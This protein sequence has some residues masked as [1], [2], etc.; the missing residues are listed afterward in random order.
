MPAYA[1]G[2]DYSN[3]T[4]S[5][6]VN[7]GTSFYYQQQAPNSSQ[8]TLWATQQTKNLNDFQAYWLISGVAGLQWPYLFDRYH[9][10]WPTNSTDY[11]NYLRPL[12]STAAQAAMT[13]VQ[14]PAA[15]APS[16]AYQ[17]PLDQPRAFL[18]SSGIFYT[19]LAPTTPPTGR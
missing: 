11:V 4:P 15:E 9:V 18:S 19:F 10:V 12:V 6:I 7:P 17:D 2:S 3:L 13:A 1:D 5:P 8:V 16:I 14:L